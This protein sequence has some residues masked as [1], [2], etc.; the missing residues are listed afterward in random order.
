MRTKRFVGLFSLLLLI[1]LGGLFSPLTA[2]GGPSRTEFPQVPAAGVPLSS[3]QVSNLGGG[4]RF[5]HSLALSGDTLVV[6]AP[7]EDSNTTGM[8]GDQGDNSA[9]G[10][11]AVY[12]FIRNGGNWVQQAY[13]KASNTGAGD[14]FGFSVAIEGDTLVVGAPFEASNATGINGIQGDNSAPGAGAVYVFTRALG[15]WTQQAYLKAS[16][17][18]AGD[19]FG[20]SVALSGDTLVVGAPFEDSDATGVNANQGSNAAPN[21]GAAYVFVRTLEAWSQQAYLKASNTDPEDRFGWSVAVAEDTAVIGAIGEAGNALGVNGNQGSNAAPNAGAAYVFVRAVGFWNPQAYVKASNTDAGDRFGW[22]V[23]VAGDTAVIGAVGEASNA[24][25]TNGNQGNDSAPGAGA[26]YVLVRTGGV[27]VQQAYLKASNTDTG[28]G[29]AHSVV[30]EGDTMVIGAP[31]EASNATGVNGTQGNNSAPG[32]GAAY[33][34]IRTGGVWIQQAYL[35]ASN[36]GAGDQFGWFVTLS[37]DTAVVGAIGEASNTTGINGNQGNNSAPGAGAA[38]VFIRAVSF[39]N[40][41]AY[42]KASNTG[43]ADRFGVF[44]PIIIR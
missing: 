28:D 23:A 6:G 27:W 36:T 9:P 29:F 17:T 10:A 21:A 24:T 3:L 20:F 1:H 2:G 42:L 4:D 22:S 41:Q 7:F 39:W 43:A 31:G 12:V 34:F 33:V 19:N 16:N 35:K 25:G 32:A 5:G 11:G 38:Y 26:A 18:G 40:Q 44:L 15:V 8:N 37:G 13:L 14:N 30:L